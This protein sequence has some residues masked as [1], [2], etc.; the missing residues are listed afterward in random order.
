M[1]CLKRVKIYRWRQ[2]LVLDVV[3]P[4]RILANTQTGKEWEK[5]LRSNFDL[6]TF[7]LFPFFVFFCSSGQTCQL[8]AIGMFKK[9]ANGTRVLCTRKEAFCNIKVWFVMYR[10]DKT[11]ASPGGVPT[12]T[13]GRAAVRPPFEHAKC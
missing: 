6:Y 3:P 11:L 5:N 10:L 13:S 7:F 12:S 9:G 4:N 8:V 1:A 2:Y